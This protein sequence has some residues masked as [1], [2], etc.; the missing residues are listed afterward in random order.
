MPQYQPVTSYHIYSKFS[1]NIRSLNW[2]SYTLFYEQGNTIILIYDNRF[3]AWW[4]WELPVE[5]TKLFIY[6]GKLYLL[7]EGCIYE[8]SSSTNNYFDLINTTRK[9]IDWFIESQ[10]LH[11]NANN[12]YKHISNLT[13]SSVEESDVP[14]SL[15]L[16]VKNY[17]KWVDNGK[18]E[19]F[20]YHIDVIRTY[21]KRVNYA[22]VCEFQY[23]LSSDNEAVINTPLALSGI[24]IKYKIGGQVR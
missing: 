6:G 16:N 21:I 3:G 5:L 13:L 9:P 23:K 17:R 12:Y 19:N 20:D 8:F 22:K 7:S 14:I 24:V 2:K 11:L 15:N 1:N 10:K 4:Q 18:A